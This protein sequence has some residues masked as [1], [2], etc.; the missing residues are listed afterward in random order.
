MGLRLAE[1]LGSESDV[2]HKVYD[3]IIKKRKRSASYRNYYTQTNEIRDKK[4]KNRKSVARNAHNVGSGRDNT[5]GHNRRVKY[6]NKQRIPIKSVT[7]RKSGRRVLNDH[8]NVDENSN[9]ITKSNYLRAKPL[10]DI[11]LEQKPKLNKNIENKLKKSIKKRREVKAE[12]E[13]N[14]EPS[15]ASDLN[16]TSEMQNGLRTTD[17]IVANE[18]KDILSDDNSSDKNPKPKTAKTFDLKDI[19]NKRNSKESREIMEPIKDLQTGFLVKRKA[20]RN[21]DSADTLPLESMS[22]GDSDLAIIQQREDRTVDNEDSDANKWRKKQNTDE[23]IRKEFYENIAKTL[24]TMRKKRSYDNQEFDDIEDSVADSDQLI[25]IDE[26]GEDKDGFN[27]NPTQV[28][29]RTTDDSD[30]YVIAAIDDDKYPQSPNIV[31]DD[32]DNTQEGDEDNDGFDWQELEEKSKLKIK[33]SAD[34]YFGDLEAGEETNDINIDSDRFT[35]INTKLESIEDSLINEAM[36][37]IRETA[38]KGSQSEAQNSRRIAN[39][40]DAAYDIE[41]MRTALEDLGNAFHRISTE[42]KGNDNELTQRTNDQLRVRPAVSDFEALDHNIGKRLDLFGEFE[43]E[44]IKKDLRD[45][46]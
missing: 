45:L 23:W 35:R 3:R 10:S 29:R 19:R 43:F 28:G 27:P 12:M 15:L 38:A 46:R 42:N 8:F 41:D 36:D 26:S 34:S 9:S 21:G 37:L 30:D 24:A 13:V 14:G 25:A 33:R 44:F 6:E 32:N 17:K 31:N 40:L 11:R 4:A 1:I 16:R 7:K 18:L 20:K 5:I 39:R 22:D 2:G